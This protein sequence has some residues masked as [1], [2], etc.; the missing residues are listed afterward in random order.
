MALPQVSRLKKALDD[1]QCN[2]GEQQQGGAAVGDGATRRAALSGSGASSSESGAWSPPLWLH[3]TESKVS[4]ALN[5]AMA[6]VLS[7][8]LMQPPRR[9]AK[10][11]RDLQ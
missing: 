4:L 2:S 7:L 8:V 9:P 6:V 10:S 5:L 11:S 1:V 3:W